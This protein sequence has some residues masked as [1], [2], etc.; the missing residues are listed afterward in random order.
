M[1]QSNENV[2]SMPGLERQAEFNIRPVLHIPED[3]ALCH[4]KYE[5]EM[6]TTWSGN[7]SGFILMPIS[8]GKGK[9]AQLAFRGQLLA[10][11][12]VIEQL[13]EVPVMAAWCGKRIVILG[14]EYIDLSRQKLFFQVLS[15]DDSGNVKL[16]RQMKEEPVPVKSFALVHLF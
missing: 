13:L 7:P 9:D 14:S 5:K 8:G 15:V 2:L 3:A 4:M 16:C 10:N 1:N 11:C 12:T 6:P